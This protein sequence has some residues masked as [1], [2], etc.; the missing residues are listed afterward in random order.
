MAWIM[1]LIWA[2]CCAGAA[3][4]AMKKWGQPE[5]EVSQG[6]RNGILIAAA[7]GGAAAGFFTG[8][9]GMI[10]AYTVRCLAALALVGAGAVVDFHLRRVPNLCSLLL[11]AVG[12]A[13]IVLDFLLAPE[14]AKAMLIYCLLGGIGMLACLSLCRLIS[15]GGIGIGDVK[16]LSAM[17]F[18][19]GLE[20]AFL[21]LLAAQ[22]LA[23]LAAIVLLVTK[24]AKWK[25]S[26][27]FAP[28]LWVGLL[29]CLCL[30]ITY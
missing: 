21:A 15:R 30:G 16:I 13:C 4:A 26:L 19:L 17:G 11:L 10:L 24:R 22:I 6:R 25:D 14:T 23:V 7:L 8:N 20:T 12:T 9:A 3:A 1:A 2:V 28:F 27:P 29:L 5:R 18:C